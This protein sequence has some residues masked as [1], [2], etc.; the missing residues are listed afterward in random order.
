MMNKEYANNLKLHEIIM[1][2]TNKISYAMLLTVLV[3][4]MIHTS[5]SAKDFNEKMGDIAT[6]T[7]ENIRAIQKGVENT[8]L[9]SEKTKEGLVVLRND[10]KLIND[11]SRKLGNKR[12]ADKLKGAARQ[13]N[14][15]ITKMYG[16]SK[17]LIRSKIGKVS[18]KLIKGT[19]KKINV[20]ENV[21]FW[22]KYAI[23]AKNLAQKE[24]VSIEEIANLGMD[25]FVK[26][27]NDIIPHSGDL[28][29]FTGDNIK[30][31]RLATAKL[32]DAL[33]D[34][35]TSDAD[36]LNLLYEK[37]FFKLRIKNPTYKAQIQQVSDVNDLQKIYSSIL[38]DEFKQYEKVVKRIDASIERVQNMK[39]LP[40]KES[41]IKSLQ[42]LKRLA[43]T[44][45]NIIKSGGDLE[46]QLSDIF[47]LTAASIIA[48]K[49]DQ[50][51][52]QTH[53][54]INAQADQLAANKER[55]LSIANKA[56]ESYNYDEYSPNSLASV[57]NRIAGQ[58]QQR[59]KQEIRN[60]YRKQAINEKYKQKMQAERAAK[61][62]Q[63][64]QRIKQ[65]IRNQYRKQAINEKYKQ[66]MQAERAAKRRQE[67]QRIKQK[68]EKINRKTQA[69]RATSSD[70][71]RILSATDSLRL[72]GNFA[73]G[74]AYYDKLYT[75]KPNKRFG[76]T[77]GPYRNQSAP[78][79]KNG[80]NKSASL[81]FDSLEE[82]TS[83]SR[84]FSDRV[85]ASSEDYGD[86]NHTAWGSWSGGQN[87]RLNFSSSGSIDN[88]HG[89]YWVYG[90]RPGIADIPK[91]GTAR[92]VGQLMG[93][94]IGER[95]YIRERSPITGDIKMTVIFQDGNNSIFGSLNLKRSGKDWA[96]ASFNTLNARSTPNPK[97]RSSDHFSTLLHIQDGLHP[98]DGGRLTGSFFGTNAAEAGG[99][100]HLDKYTGNDIGFA[101]GIFRAKNIGS[102][103]D[104]ISD[105]DRLKLL[106]GNH[107]FA[108]NTDTSP[109]I[110]MS[111]Y[112][113]YPDPL[114]YNL[115]LPN[116]RGL[117][118]DSGSN[119]TLRFS[120][121]K[122]SIPND[123]P[124]K[125]NT[126][127]PSDRIK[128]HARDY[129]DYSYIAWGS[130][131]SGKNTRL[132]DGGRQMLTPGGRWIYG[133]RLKAA[134]IPRSGS[135]RY[136]GQLMGGWV[137]NWKM[138]DSAREMDSITGD[139]N[140][141]VTFQD[142]DFSISGTM[143]LNR[144]GEDWATAR[145]DKRNAKVSS[146]IL[147][148]HHF[149]FISGGVNLSGSFFGANAAE[150]GGT[151]SYGKRE[152]DETAVGV[153]RAKKQ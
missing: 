109:D 116:D 96:I 43:K 69:E 80:G 140:M 98:N 91:S 6:S 64:Q 10:V 39:R 50:Q 93:D 45:L 5:V 99:T 28:T 138:H 31:I 9:F 71:G 137:S 55:I 144:N 95:K 58:E 100:F 37:E 141:A 85:K 40:A 59:I 48:E 49:A 25:G 127:V 145:F 147:W 81:F 131:S 146:S 120:E 87:T 136:A 14:K 103:V 139:I 12:Y 53:D 118:N 108:I 60:Q 117:P 21:T 106:S 47:Y 143:N 52:Q 73:Y 107:A 126:L 57:E 51:Q 114:Y 16:A 97:T 105:V 36:Y 113:S 104:N 76:S 122:E 132:I 7:A 151:F 13:L 26:I 83:N 135:A 17:K 90:Q 78:L 72:G 56:N 124:A 8:K 74:M 89:G 2:G 125:G 67:Q 123:D 88:I 33:N 42:I 102:V 18:K 142:N 92:Y 63:E 1:L 20:A 153:F 29:K 35:Y 77:L 30:G 84:R 133:Q 32:Q 128:V 94:F 19:G 111:T 23:R 65:E 129:G 130:W 44:R 148:A 121:L 54:S 62:R 115:S 38:E 82:V 11:I 15:N 149:S 41:R 46:K 134:D 61:R 70:V 22:T 24:N 112:G 119:L 3:A 150:V 66:K 27:A 4:V 101:N 152:N 86:Y 68:I 79:T 75:D 110:D 34:D